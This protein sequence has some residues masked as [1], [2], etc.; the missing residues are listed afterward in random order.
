MENTFQKAYEKKSN[1]DGTIELKFKTSRVGVNTSGLKWQ[2]I[3]VPFWLTSCAVT[4]PFIP[5]NRV[6]GGGTEVDYLYWIIASG[7][8]AILLLVK[9]RDT[10]DIITIKPGEGIKFLGNSLPYKD[11]GIIGVMTHTSGAK[12]TSY[13][14]A[15]TN[16]TQAQITRYVT[17]ELAKAVQKEI[18]SYSNVEWKPER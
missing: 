2:L 14:Y 13:V 5:T 7:I 18:Q 16:G 6:R 3:S 15:E 4:Y 8:L 11:M 12:S 1:D 17:P 10:K 9:F